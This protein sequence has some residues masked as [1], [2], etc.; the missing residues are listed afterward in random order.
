[1]DKILDEINGF[2]RYQKIVLFII[3]AMTSLNAMAIYATVFIAAEPELLCK[4]TDDFNK[5]IDNNLKCDIWK[6]FT[7]SICYLLYI[8]IFSWF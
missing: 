5:T 7:K 3:G 6:N 2:G 8:S 4:L 1:M